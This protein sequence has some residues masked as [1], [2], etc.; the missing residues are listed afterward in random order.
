[1]ETANRLPES[2]LE[3]S[4]SFRNEGEFYHRKNRNNRK[5]GWKKNR[6]DSCGFEKNLSNVLLPSPGR[7]DSHS[8]AL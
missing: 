4:A 6:Q 3:N 1:M 5:N 8:R 7:E 2:F